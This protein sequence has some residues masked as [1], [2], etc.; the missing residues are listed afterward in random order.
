MKMGSLV[1]L[2]VGL[3]LT[4]YFGRPAQKV[5]GFQGMTLEESYKRMVTAHT[6]MSLDL[7]RC[8]KEL[9]REREVAE[10]SS[11]F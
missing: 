4:I 3:A 1:I 10:R 2:V 11:R 9:E 5:I 8:F 6:E 7:H